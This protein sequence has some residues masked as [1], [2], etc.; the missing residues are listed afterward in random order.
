MKRSIS[1]TPHILIRA[2]NSS[3]WNTVDFA[4]IHLTETWKMLLAQR[5]LAVSRFAADESFHNLTYWESPLGFYS[6]PTSR[7]YTEKLMN[8]EEEWTYVTLTEDQ[9]QRFPVP[10][11]ELEDH[12]LVITGHG[13]ANFV[14]FNSR[15]SEQYWTDWFSISELIGR[16]TKRRR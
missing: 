11:N 1:P 10:V 15:T 9:E 3:R 4:L 6:Y 2:S 7:L 16:T 5:L 13:Y 12:Q 14:A 8:P